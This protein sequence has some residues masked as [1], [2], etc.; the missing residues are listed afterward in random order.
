VILTPTTP[1]KSGFVRDVVERLTSKPIQ[2]SR[3]TKPV[4]PFRVIWESNIVEEKSQM[5]STLDCTAKGITLQQI[6]DVTSGDTS[7]LSDLREWAERKCR[8]KGQIHF[9]AAEISAATDRILQY[10]RAFLP[11]DQHGVIRAMTINQAKNREFD[12]VIVLW[13]FLI[14][15]DL[16]SQRRR[17]YNA[18][19]RAHNWAVVI[20]QDDA[21]KASR[22]LGPPFSRALKVA[23]TVK[24]NG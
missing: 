7:A 10:R 19:T 1:K 23:A 17:L 13:P 16:D 22:L 2:L 6:Q 4:G 18:L 5:V 9:S 14:G 20:V 21:T 11:T 3:I 15:G 8:M 24:K 12:G